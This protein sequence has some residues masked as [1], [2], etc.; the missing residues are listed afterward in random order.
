MEF[1][2]QFDDK[3]DVVNYNTIDTE[4]FRKVF[5]V[6]VE[7]QIDELDTKTSEYLNKECRHFNYF[8]DDMKDEFLTTT[9]ISLSPE[10]RKQLWESEV[11]K[12]LPNLMARSTHNKCLRTEH[13]Y[14]KKYRDVIKILEDYC[15][16]R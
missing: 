7:D 15:E 1:I 5:E 9:S 16:D 8:I 12:N 11:D 6:Y 13:N 10:L 14:D 3:N 4:R 2:V